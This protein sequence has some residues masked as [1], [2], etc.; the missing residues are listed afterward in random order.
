M[1]PCPL[2]CSPGV[3]A[4]PAQPSAQ[5]APLHHLWPPCAPRPRSLG[6]GGGG[7]GVPG[8]ASHA[9]HHAGHAARC[10]P[11]RPAPLPTRPG[12]AHGALLARGA[13]RQVGRGECSGSLLCDPLR[14][15]PSLHAPAMCTPP[16]L[17][18]QPLRIPSCRPS[19]T[20][21]LAGLQVQLREARAA[22]REPQPLAGHRPAS[23]GSSV[24]LS[25]PAPAGPTELDTAS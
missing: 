4:P 18:N 12:C 1:R 11:A 16:A 25:E 24:H 13:G 21:I 7:R 5:L 3:A 23:V 20:D 2:D 17:T 15:V 9:D 14:A 22:G 8:V 6:A 10:P 19:F